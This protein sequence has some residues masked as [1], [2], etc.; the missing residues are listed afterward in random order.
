MQRQ[1]WYT[2]LASTNRPIFGQEKFEF[3]SFDELFKEPEPISKPDVDPE[4]LKAFCKKH[5]MNLLE[6]STDVEF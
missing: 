5:N 2:W 4:Q 1:A 6:E 3:K